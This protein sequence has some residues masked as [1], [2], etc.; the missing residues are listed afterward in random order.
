M[1]VENRTGPHESDSQDCN[2]CFWR[3]SPHDV[4]LYSSVEHASPQRQ[5]FVSPILT[6]AFGVNLVFI[7]SDRWWRLHAFPWLSPSCPFWKRPWNG[8]KFALLPA[9]SREGP[10][11][12]SRPKY[13]VHIQGSRGGAIWE[14]RLY[15]VT[16]HWWELQHW[17]PSDVDNASK[18]MKIKMKGRHFYL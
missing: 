7:V 5:A 12:C 1:E 4:V 16:G 15:W 9:T 11:E 14:R 10:S 18:T 13:G 2:E 17:W 6:P 3:R 8:D